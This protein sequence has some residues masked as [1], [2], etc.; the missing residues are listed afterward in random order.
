MSE[1]RDVNGVLSIK[2]VG[3]GEVPAGRVRKI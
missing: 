2:V 3:A 1:A